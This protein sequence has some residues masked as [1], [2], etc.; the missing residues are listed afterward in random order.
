MAFSYKLV[1]VHALPIHSVISGTIWSPVNGDTQVGDVAI[2]LNLH[3][4][5]YVV[6]D[7]IKVIAEVIQ[8]LPSMGTDHKGVVHVSE[9]TEKFMGSHFQCLFFDVLHEQTGD[10]RGWDEPMSILKVSS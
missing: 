3:G 4:E 5:Q 6:M 2:C 1:C 10:H 9:P 7:A 8:L